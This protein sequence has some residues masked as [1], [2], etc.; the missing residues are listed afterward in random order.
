MRRYIILLIG[1]VWLVSCS[2][3]EPKKPGLALNLP[4]QTLENATM[5]FTVDGI[6]S[7][8]IKAK[9]VAKWMDK[10][11]TLAKSLSVDFFDERGAHTS[12]LDADSGWIQEKRQKMEVLGNVSVLTDDSVK[13]ESQS[14]KWDPKSNRIT[15]DDFVKITKGKDLM[16]GY[17]FEADQY[18][19]NMKIKKMVKGEI[20]KEKEETK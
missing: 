5:V 9:S 6:K 12:H 7:T 13:L 17:G 2:K 10:D 16:S 11:L 18:L 1:L 20:T 14:L 19:R 8:V 3:E 4:D 15:T